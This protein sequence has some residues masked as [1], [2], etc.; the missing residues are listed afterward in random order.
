MWTCL[1]AI[2]TM[3]P[4][5]IGNPAT[6]I[7][8]SVGSPRSHSGAKSSTHIVYGSVP[9]A[10]GLSLHGGEFGLPLARNP[11]ARDRPAIAARADRRIRSARLSPDDRGD[12]RFPQ[13]RLQ[14]RPLARHRDDA[15][16][17]RRR[18][19]HAPSH[20]V[21]RMER[22]EIR[23]RTRSQPRIS[24]RSIRATGPTF[25]LNHRQL[26]VDYQQHA[27]EF[28]AAAQ[29]QP[30]RR[31]HAVDPLLAREPRIFFDAI[32][33]YFGGAA[34]YRE[35]RAVLEKV[36]GVVA[37]LAI[38]DH[39]PVQIQNTIEFETIERHPAW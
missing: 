30:A 13:R 22:S 19:H 31:D 21:A 12:R 7:T 6:G 20:Y 10:A 26:A 9:A 35:H 18:R 39:A 32:D 14:I 2:Q 25:P 29:D 24:L 38:G 5:L 1:Q 23:E 28:V 36:D 8:Q 3:L 34:E 4:N 16:R 37:P 17:A 33:G 15:A 11:S 27:I